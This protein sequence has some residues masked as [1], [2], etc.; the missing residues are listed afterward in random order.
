MC[1]WT[2]PR[3]KRSSHCQRSWCVP[4]DFGR[5]VFRLSIPSAVL[6]GAHCAVCSQGKGRIYFFEREHWDVQADRH[7]LLDAILV[8]AEPPEPEDGE[9]QAS[10]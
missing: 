10:E 2:Y 9:G 1:V 5:S 3:H 6:S 8:K 7:A 4:F